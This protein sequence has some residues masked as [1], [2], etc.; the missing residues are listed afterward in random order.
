[1]PLL[2]AKG[3]V[4]HSTFKELHF[5]LTNSREQDSEMLRSFCAQLDTNLR[6]GVQKH[7]SIISHY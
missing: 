3:L 7:F 2:T 4:I 1:M 6:V 5:L